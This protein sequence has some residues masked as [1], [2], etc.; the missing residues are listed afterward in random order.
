[1]TST[2]L[3]FER[4][5]VKPATIIDGASNTIMIGEKYLSPLNYAMGNTGHDNESM[6]TG[7]NN[8]QFR[9]TNA[10]FP[11]L[12]DREGYDNGYPFGG[13]HSSGCNFA[14]CD[15]SVRTISYSIS[16]TAFQTLGSRNGREVAPS[17]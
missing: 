13:P 10:S 4:S 6:Y 5:L 15:G 16:P 1:M 8:D 14:F 7:Y 9:S 12:Q 2:G 17:F 3:S 11:P